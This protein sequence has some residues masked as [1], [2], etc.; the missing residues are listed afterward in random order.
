MKDDESLSLAK[1]RTFLAV[2]RTRFSA[3][4]TLSSWVRTGLTS[5]G[6]GFAIIRL[7]V[8]Q[9]I[10]HRI[11][12]HI[13]GE[14]LIIWGIVILIFSLISYKRFCK[15]IKQEAIKTNELWITTTV[16]VFVLVSLFLFFATIN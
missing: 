10:S 8:F 14:I 5:V 3:E 16:I 9:A 6:G 1:E 11:I 2:E 12:A 7:I 13:I 15:K 4:R